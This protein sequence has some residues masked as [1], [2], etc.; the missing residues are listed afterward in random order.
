MTTHNCSHHKKDTCH[1]HKQSARQELKGW[2]PLAFSFLML[3]GGLLQDFLHPALFEIPGLRLAWYAAACLPVAIPIWKETK[4]AIRDKDYFNEFTLMLLASVGAF[5][6]G[7]YPEAVGVLLFYS[8]GEEL[9][10]RAVAG[11]KRSIQSLIDLKPSWTTVVKGGRAIKAKPEDVAPGETIEIPAGGRVPLDGTLTTDAAAFDTAAL[12]GESAPRLIRKGE[13]VAAGM[14]STDRTVRLQVTHPYSDSSLARILNMVEDAAKR[15]APAELLIRRLA[16]LYTPVVFALA[17]AIALLPP[18]AGQLTGWESEPFSDW[19]Y[20]GLVFLVVSCPCALVISIP[21]C[22]FSGIGMASRK[23][24]LFKGGNYLDAVARVNAVVFDK[25]GTLTMGTF[26]VTKID[27]PAVAPED[28]LRTAAS[29][30]SHST[31]PVACAVVE[32]AKEEGLQLIPATAV[33]EVAGKG[34]VATVEG[35]EVLA[36]NLKLLL[37]RGVTLPEGLQEDESYTEVY[38]AIGGEYTGRISLADAPREDAALAV[39]RLKEEHV[40]YIG[41]FSGDKQSIVERLARTLG[42]AHF[43]GG[44]L[45]EGKLKQMERLMAGSG[46]QTVAFVGDGINDAPV[47]ALS[48][49][50]FAMG[51]GGSDAAVETAD[52][53]IQSDRLSKVAEAIR[54]GRLTKRLAFSSIALSLGAKA[55]VLIAGALGMASLWVAVMADT[56]ITLLCVLN[57]FAFSKFLCREEA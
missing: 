26:K 38:C 25:T 30:E 43:H 22:Y 34:L 27:S 21:L 9:Q 48:H 29:A 37:E 55:A 56:G 47:L 24:I 45:P 51:A 31:H 28:L 33:R 40:G 20:K 53:V 44:L 23:G 18:L 42:I 4:E 11:A 49:V 14:I 54:L 8:I 2:L 7:E 6:I 15:K 17:A 39:K 52:V 32:R 35:K 36:G 13:E 46:K 12:T 3:G 5:C 10:E 50:G 16:R 57:I 41:I 1:C 19:I